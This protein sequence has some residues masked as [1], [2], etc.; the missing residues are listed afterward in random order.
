MKGHKKLVRA[1]KTRR[2]P[3]INDD[4]IM[5]KKDEL[6]A[7]ASSILGPNKKTGRDHKYGD[8]GLPYGE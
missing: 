5:P 1:T 4:S 8:G 3:K 2:R 7:I 6:M